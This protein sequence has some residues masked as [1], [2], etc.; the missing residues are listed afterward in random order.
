MMNIWGSRNRR[1]LVRFS[2]RMWNELINELGRRGRGIRE[3][4]AF[5]L[6]ARE[7]NH[8][9]VVRFVYLDDLDPN[10]LQ[11]NIHFDGRAY[12]KLWDICDEENLVVI[13]DVHT[14]PGSSVRQSNIDAANP[15]IARRGHVAIIVPHFAM[16]PSAPRDLGVHAYVQNGWQ[17]WTGNNAAMRIRIGGW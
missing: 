14:H 7:G 8:R 6:A 4:G 17:V 5:L 12:S 10:C 3:S 16:R 15:M 1:V 11:G 13:A 2:S 9:D